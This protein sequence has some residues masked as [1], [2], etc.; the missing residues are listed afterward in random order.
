MA[1]L[2]C[3]LLDFLSLP[4]EPRDDIDPV[5]QLKDKK[6][7]KRKNA[8]PKL[9]AEATSWQYDVDGSKFFRP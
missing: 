4:L 1:Q 3:L 7:D 2:T 5:M 6:K 9:A 8:R